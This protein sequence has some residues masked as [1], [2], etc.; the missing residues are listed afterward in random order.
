MNAREDW[1][2]ADEI[3]AW[4]LNWN[5]DLWANM[6]DESLEAMREEYERSQIEDAQA[7]ADYAANKEKY[8]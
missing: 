1:P 7:A 6:T 5:A 2:L 3:P 4:W 8:K